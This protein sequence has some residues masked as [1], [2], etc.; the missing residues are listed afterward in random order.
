MF[1][2]SCKDTF[3]PDND[4]HSKS[5]RLL[6]DPAFAE[7]ILINGYTGLGNAYALDETA[8]DDAVTNVKAN[9]YQ[10]M[11][12]GEW[13]AM[14]NPISVWTTAYQ[15]IWY[16]N[17]YLSIVNK[18]DFAWEDKGSPAAV[19]D[20][21]FKK[22]FTGE[23][24][25][26]RAW[27]NFKLLQNHGGIATDGNPKGFVILKNALTRFDDYNLPRNSY[28]ECVKFILEDIQSA[29]SLLPNVYADITGDVAYN[30]VFGNSGTPPKNANRVD[31]RF[32]KALKSRVMLY[33]ASQSIYTATA[34]WD[35]AAVA[36]AALLRTVSGGINGIAGMSATG[37]NF[38]KNSADAEIIFR[39]DYTAVNTREVANFPP[40]RFG[41]GQ[42]NPSQNLVDAFPMAN[43]YPITNALGLYNA[44][45]PYA[46]RDPRLKAYII[47]SGSNILTPVI[48]TN[49]EDLKDGLNQTVTSTRTGYYLSKLLLPTINLTPP[50]PSTGRNYYTI[51]RYTEMFLNYA[52]AANEAWGP[53]G[54]PKGY[55]FTAKTII[56]AIRKRA[57]IAVADPYLAGITTQSE[58]RDLIRNERR[59]ELCF[60]GFRFWDMRRWN[61]NL[62]ETVR[63]MKIAGGT[64]SII[65]VE[66]RLYKPYMQY[67]PI[68]YQETLKSNLTI[69]NN[70]W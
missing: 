42:T 1:L 23:A 62:A 16:L 24:K 47:Y 59:I 5:D 51:F 22:R 35:S 61:L 7:G 2:I 50:V 17:Y 31:G 28:D 33:V 39:N 45:A 57:G 20:T 25:V 8:T 55:G 36:S 63:G 30:K 64:Y 44:A 60:E 4:N 13:S 58:M 6:T 41:A 9:A 70:G 65:N 43:G 69:Q 54:D 27:Y 48:N 34:K 21:L 52:E 38:W 67:G 11:A 68:P 32:A 15:K 66:D 26:L 14:F 37:V 29:I 10:R 46:G 12:T 3:A 19:R 18:I 56:G 53:T 40:S 49:V